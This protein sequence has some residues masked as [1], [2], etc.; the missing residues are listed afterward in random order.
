MDGM[1]GVEL[2]WYSSL[3]Y[4]SDRGEP[5]SVFRDRWLGRLHA[6]KGLIFMRLIYSLCFLQAFR[7]NRGE[8]TNGEAQKTLDVNTSTEADSTAHSQQ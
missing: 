2:A 8:H 4:D 1:G 3:R 7:G 5:I 6:C